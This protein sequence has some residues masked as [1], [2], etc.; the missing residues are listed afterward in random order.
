M[1]LKLHRGSTHKLIH[2]FI[3]DSTKTDGS[4]LAG[5]TSASGGLVCA[6][7][8]E[9]DSSGATALALAVGTLG[10]WSLGGFVAVDGTLFPGL[11]ELG[12]PD[13]AISTGNSVKLILRGATNMAVCP[14]EIELDSVNY[15]DGQAFGLASLPGAGV[16]AVSPVAASVAGNVAGSVGSVTAPVTV[17]ANND[18]SGYS[19]AD[20]GLDAVKG[21]GVWSFRQTGQVI[22]QLLQGKRSGMPAP[23]T[24][25]TVTFQDNA[26]A[27]Y[28][29]VT[30]DPA[31]NITGSNITPPA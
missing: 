26:S 29:T 4:G 18:K 25:G 20:A 13:A 27:A 10:T 5:L 8:R 16:L 3:Q 22:A 28:G 14:V 21:W 30:L 24:G 19:L 23:G 12:L 31:G 6:Y 11:Y 17:G 7:F 9:G 2:V 1:T 15:Q